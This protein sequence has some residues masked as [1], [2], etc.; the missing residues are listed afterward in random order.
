MPCTQCMSPYT[1]FR[2]EHGCSNCGYG[3]CEKCLQ[4]KWIL[5]AISAKPVSVCA[6]C[7]GILSGK[8]APIQNQEKDRSDEDWPPPSLRKNYP[9]KA[10]ANFQN[11]HSNVGGGGGKVQNQPPPKKDDF[12]LEEI[13]AR[14]ARLKEVPIEE[15][16]NPGLM[17]LP[18]ASSNPNPL[19]NLATSQDEAKGLIEAYSN[20]PKTEYEWSKGKSDAET[21][22]IE[23]R[24]AALKGVPVEEVRKP[25]LMIVNDD[26]DD[27]VS[28][29]EDAQ[30][31]LKQAEN[32]SKSK[33]SDHCYKNE[34]LEDDDV[35]VNSSVLKKIVKE[36]E[37][38]PSMDSRTNPFLPD[39]A[40]TVRQVRLQAEE[41]ERRAMEFIRQSHE[42]N[43]PPTPRPSDFVPEDPQ[44][45]P[46]KNQK[47]PESSKKKAGL[48]SRLFKSSKD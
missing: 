1:I 48:F 22:K 40:D 13:H 43:E 47:S 16:K 36:A 3:F 25:R 30:E 45:D 31:L 44:A 41:A 20:L 11:S 23:E 12:D 14:V 10:N 28:L 42:Q 17:F 29:S 4:H 39:F 5:P 15:V 26:S 19:N 2:K 37:D 6:S 27:D 9:I 18:S 7:Y 33:K 35:S 32:E 34:A 21:A 24:L 46:S 8:A 38:T